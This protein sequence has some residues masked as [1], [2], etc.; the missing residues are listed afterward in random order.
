MKQMG[1]WNEYETKWSILEWWT[2]YEANSNVEK[3]S[4]RTT[5][6]IWNK[7]EYEWNMKQMETNGTSVAGEWVMVEANENCSL[8]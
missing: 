1:K 5:N 3:K 6:E 4:Y 7:R 2:E 8:N